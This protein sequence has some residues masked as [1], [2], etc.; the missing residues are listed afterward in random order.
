MNTMVS[1]P[2]VEELR[3][4]IASRVREGIE[5]LLKDAEAMRS[6]G[7]LA[8]IEAARKDYASGNARTQEQVL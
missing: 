7:Y 2:C 8:S 3:S 4:M 5:D 1:E 6:V